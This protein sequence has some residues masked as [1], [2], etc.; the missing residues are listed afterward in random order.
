MVLD[1]KALQKIKGNPSAEVAPNRRLKVNP[2]Q[3]YVYDMPKELIYN[4]NK[5]FPL[6]NMLK[7]VTDA[8]E[9]SLSIQGRKFM[10][11]L[12][13]EADSERF[14]DRTAEMIEKVAQQ[15]GIRFPHVFERY[16]ELGILALR[17]RDAW[18]V[19]EATTRT[20]KVRSYNCSLSKLLAEKGVKNCGLFCLAAS[21]TAAE[22]IRITL[23]ITCAND[24]MEICEFT[25][26][27]Q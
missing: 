16:I 7:Q 23:D 2:G 1:F 14:R 21:K 3:D 9:E 4:V 12:I 5:E 17:P 25:Y 13:R 22:R 15:T 18:T 6:E 26:R 27:T 10:T 20:L 19:T 24:N 8:G 11:I